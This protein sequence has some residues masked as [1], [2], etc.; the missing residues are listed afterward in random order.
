[1]CDTVYDL[2]FLNQMCLILYLLLF[3]INFTFCVSINVGMFYYI[4]YI[5]SMSKGKFLLHKVSA[6]MFFSKKKKSV[7]KFLMTLYDP[8]INKAIK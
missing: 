4:I 5:I 1:M 7:L 6:G 8:L 2:K 3:L